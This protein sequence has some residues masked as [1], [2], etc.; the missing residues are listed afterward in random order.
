MKYRIKIKTFESGRRD[1]TPQVKLR[2]FWQGLSWEGEPTGTV[3]FEQ[4]TR[5]AAL[6]RIDKHF[7]GNTKMQ[8]IEFEYINK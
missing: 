6:N 1:Y 2:F 3:M 4:D 8:S 7:A 5:E